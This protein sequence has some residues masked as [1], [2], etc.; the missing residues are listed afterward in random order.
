MF[1]DPLTAW[2]VTLIGDGI[3]ISS[4]H[5]SNSKMAQHY[6]E[7]G[8][9]TNDSMNTNIL[10]IRNKGYYSAENALEKIKHHVEYAQNSYAIKYGYVKLEISSESY[11]FIIKLCEECRTD[12]WEK[13]ETY[14]EIY[15]KRIRNGE[16]EE[17]LTRVKQEIEKFKSKANS[18]QSIL[19]LAKKGKDKAIVQEEERARRFAEKDSDGVVILKSILAVGLCI[20]GFA[21]MMANGG[22]IGALALIGS[23]IGGY[24][25]FKK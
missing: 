11:E 5:T 16:P 15:Q 23:A 19:D 20:G 25:I 9:L 1:F 21:I 22:V 7:C 17:N 18:Y 4:N 2:L 10:N 6:R 8:K 12:F 3:V 14:L 13:Y 24:F